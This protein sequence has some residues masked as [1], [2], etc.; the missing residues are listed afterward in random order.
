L[1]E[2]DFETEITESDIQEKI[3][4]YNKQDKKAGRE[5]KEDEILTMEQVKYLLENPVCHRCHRLVSCNNW[6]LDRKHNDKL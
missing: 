4:S 1:W 5:I 2:D 3:D 6:S